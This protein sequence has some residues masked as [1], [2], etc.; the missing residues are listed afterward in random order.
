MKRYGITGK[1]HT[2]ITDY[3]TNRK[4][5]V[6]IDGANSEYISLKSGVPQGSI[7]GPLLFL[8]YINDLPESINTN[9]RIYA[10][11][12]SVFTDY[13]VKKENNLE[14]V[15]DAATALQHDIEAVERWAK[16]WL[17]DFNPAKTE[18]LVFSRKR[19]NH[20]IPELQ[21]GNSK[22]KEMSSHKHLGMTLQKDAK[23]SLHIAE[24][25]HKSKKKVDILRSLMYQLSRK[26][27]EKLYLSYIRPGLEYGSSVWDNCSKQEK[28]N[29]E[30]VQRAALRTICGAK[31]GTSHELLY[32]ETGIEPLQNRR[33]RKKLIQ[34]YKINH[35]KCPST[36]AELNPVTTRT[37]AP[38][39]NFRVDSN[40]T[41]MATHSKTMHESF[42]PSTIKQWPTKRKKT[43]KEC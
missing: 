5:R 16:N 31:K 21:M 29:L 36:L 14:Q 26:S 11:D 37:R 7:L 12:S 42:Y 8:L 10:D 25:V 19:T 4:Q 9:I 35:N 38:S 28:E 1:L 27:L 30:N 34:L 41:I 17:V 22:I 32:G 13:E 6:A 3:L 23:W 39:Y 40:T 24:M 15:N 43:G 33:D 20:I 18:S 2:W